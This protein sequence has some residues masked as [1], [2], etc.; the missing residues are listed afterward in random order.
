MPVRRAMGRNVPTT[1][2]RLR[3]LALSLLALAMGIIAS[4]TV[5]AANLSLESTASATL[6]FHSTWSPMSIEITPNHDLVNGIQ[7]GK[8]D[9]GVVVAGLRVACAKIAARPNPNGGLKIQECAD[10]AK[11]TGDS[12]LIAVRW[13]PAS[14]VVNPDSPWEAELVGTDDPSHRLPV[15]VAPKVGGL[16]PLGALRALEYGS[17]FT[18]SL[19]DVIGQ[20]T[21]LADIKINTTNPLTADKYPMTLEAGVWQP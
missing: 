8:N 20:A 7:E 19:T 17:W 10:D 6:R 14:A 18:W 3:P 4:S 11:I 13:D 5:Q 1:D 21:A 16:G 9:W 12:T 15:T 2:L